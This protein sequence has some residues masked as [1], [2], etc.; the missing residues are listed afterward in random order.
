[1]LRVFIV[2]GLP[3]VAPSYF[4]ET[5]QAGSLVTVYDK[6]FKVDRVVYCVKSQEIHIKLSKSKL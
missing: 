1:M 4:T 2:D 3:Y 6:V 5:P